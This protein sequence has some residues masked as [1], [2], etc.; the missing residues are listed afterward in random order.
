MYITSIIMFDLYG[1]IRC[2]YN[3]LLEAIFVFLLVN[4]IV[5]K[6]IGMTNLVKLRKSTPLQNFMT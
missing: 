3:V 5:Y 4:N 1:H 2:Y 6:Q